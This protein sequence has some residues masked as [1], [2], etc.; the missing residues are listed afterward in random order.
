MCG[1]RAVSQAARDAIEQ[2]GT[3]ACASRLI[4][5]EKP[6]HRELERELAD[7]IGVEDRHN[8]SRRSC[9]QRHHYRSLVW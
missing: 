5:G 4:S 6:L 2:Y 3:S 8:F 9:Y 7:F 1:D